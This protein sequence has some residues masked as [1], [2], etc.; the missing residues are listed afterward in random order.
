MLI[1]LLS[2]CQYQPKKPRLDVSSMHCASIV[3]DVVQRS[4][5]VQ[6]LDALLSLG[7]MGKKNIV[8]LLLEFLTSRYQSI[9]DDRMKIK[10]HIQ[11]GRCD[12]IIHAELLHC[13]VT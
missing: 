8:G 5:D 3:H 12:G 1:P 11:C 6:D 4:Q 10:K 2:Q 9:V 13:A 7:S